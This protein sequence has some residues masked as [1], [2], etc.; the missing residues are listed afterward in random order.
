MSKLTAADRRVL[1]RIRDKVANTHWMKY[2]Y[3]MTKGPKSK[4][5]NKEMHCLVGFVNA[6]TLPPEYGAMRSGYAT[7]LGGAYGAPAIKAVQAN[8]R[9]RILEAMRA[10]VFS[11]SNSRHTSIEGFNDDRKTKREDV[12]DLLDDLIGG[13]T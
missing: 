8:R 1:Q 2:H 13:K 6:E 3:A 5:P 4:T 7:G 9:D 10:A 11:R 12:L